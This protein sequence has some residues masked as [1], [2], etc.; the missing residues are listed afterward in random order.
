MS[1]SPEGGITLF[2]I[3]MTP[4]RWL[5]LALISILLAYA[6]DRPGRR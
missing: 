5:L 6:I 2:V 3:E 4:W 1:A